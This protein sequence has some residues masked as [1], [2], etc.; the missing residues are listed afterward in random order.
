MVYIVILGH[1]ILP[2]SDLFADEG[3]SVPKI[4]NYILL[5]FPI[6]VVTCYSKLEIQFINMKPTRRAVTDLNCAK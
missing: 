6:S 4:P 2:F 3:T 1:I 5:P